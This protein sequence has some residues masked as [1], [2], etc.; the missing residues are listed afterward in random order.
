MIIFLHGEDTYRSRQKLKEL[1]AKFYKEVDS[2]GY[3]L[4]SL[5]GQDTSVEAIASALSAAPFMAAKRMVILESPQLLDLGG[6]KEESLVSLVEDVLARDTIFVVWEQGLKATQ[7]KQPFFK[8]VMKSKYIFPFPK[9]TEQEVAGWMY[10]KL[11]EEEVGIDR[12]ALGY[13]SASVGK[14]LWRAASEVSK[15]INYAKGNELGQLD[16]TAIKMMTTT[17]LE[18]DIFSLVDAVSQGRAV[19]ALAKLDKQMAAGSHALQISSMLVRQYRLLQQIKDGQSKRLPPDVIAQDFGLHPFVV[20]KMSGQA[21]GFTDEAI[22]EGYNHLAKLD[23]D[24]KSSD[25]SD[26]VLMTKV[27]G[28]LSIE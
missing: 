4:T 14:D 23:L 19:Q 18:D 15:L 28:E 26:E 6:E 24:L 5:S 13:L 27:V 22:V 10:Q 3:N 16:A 17:P 12:E 25:L 8:A 1:Q 11:Q 21:S 2:Q 7:L 20:K 9:F